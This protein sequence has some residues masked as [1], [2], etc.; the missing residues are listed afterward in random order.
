[1]MQTVCSSPKRVPE[2]AVQ[3]VHG[4]C[5]HKLS[6]GILHFFGGTFCL[7]GYCT[8]NGAVAAAHVTL[9][10]LYSCLGPS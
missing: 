10:I 9:Q 2:A 6:C 8:N 4:A 5:K 3:P 1:M 7:A